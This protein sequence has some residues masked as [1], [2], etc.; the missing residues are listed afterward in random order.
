MKTII[1]FADFDKF[2]GTRTYFFQI[3]KYFYSKN[4]QVEVVIERNCFDGEV[5]E[6]TKKYDYKVFFGRKRLVFE[7]LFPINI[8]LA[9]YDVFY[10]KVKYKL[11]EKMVIMSGKG[12]EYLFSSILILKNI[13]FIV[14]SYP[15]G[16]I[17]Y[18][19]P[20]AGL[21][22]GKTK[23]IVTV[24]NYS[25][26]KI[27]ENFGIKNSDVVT[28]VYNTVQESKF[29]FNRIK[30]PPKKVVTLGHVE[31]Y[32]NPSFWYSVA[33]KVITKYDDVEFVWYGNGPQENDIKKMIIN[34]K[35]SGRIKLMSSTRSPENALK[36]AYLYFQPSLNES[37]G[38]SV[39]E[40][41]ACGVPSIVSNIGGLPEVVEDNANGKVFKSFDPEKVS[42]MI[43][44][45]IQ[46]S[47][48]RNALGRASKK[49]YERKFSN[50]VWE[51]KMD[52][53]MKDLC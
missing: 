11:S 16:K 38:M 44:E 45:I 28:V 7:N 42:L 25:K 33:K 8:L 46:S 32:K 1:L 20:I 52:A 31:W 2:G 41:M 34:D 12:Y 22:D 37:F 23:K 48:K 43:C 30:E 50:R 18:I 26:K 15:V 49:N 6:V 4:Y 40:A 17:R 29:Q 21:L 39:L 27:E 53:F 9:F 24:S 13:N 51:L 19:V 5:A 3:L 10:W 35:V 47:T 14:H 36:D